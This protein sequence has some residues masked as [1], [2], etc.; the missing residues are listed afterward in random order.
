M[1][2]IAINGAI[3][4]LLGGAGAGIGVC[5]FSGSPEWRC[6]VF[7]TCVHASDQTCC[8]FQRTC[9]PRNC[10]E[11]EALTQSCHWWRQGRKLAKMS[12]QVLTKSSGPISKRWKF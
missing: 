11:A 10:C 6:V 5:G 1:G 9:S 12:A 7:D 3:Q 4:A 8:L 2:E